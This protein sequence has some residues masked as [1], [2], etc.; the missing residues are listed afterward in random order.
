M[1]YDII[2]RTVSARN[3]AITL[4][5]HS[6][7]LAE[8]VV[9]GTITVV[10]IAAIMGVMEKQAEKQHYQRAFRPGHKTTMELPAI[11]MRELMAS[12]GED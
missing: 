11:P 6:A 9:L 4:P 8:K 12:S 3:Y 2:R 10:T 1:A 5:P 7:S